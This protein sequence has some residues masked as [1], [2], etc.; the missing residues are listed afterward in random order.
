MQAAVAV[1]G[2]V[3][4]FKRGP[5]EIC[6]IIVDAHRSQ[7]ERQFWTPLKTQEELGQLEDLEVTGWIEVPVGGAQCGIA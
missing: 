6:N 1:S 7:E 4:T 3:P 2:V 5:A